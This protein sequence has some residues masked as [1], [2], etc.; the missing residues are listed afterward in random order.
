MT[1]SIGSD[2]EELTDRRSRFS[3]CQAVREILDLV[4]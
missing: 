3:A 4:K 1:C 2:R